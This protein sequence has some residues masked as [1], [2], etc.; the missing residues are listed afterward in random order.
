MEAVHGGPAPAP[1]QA[2][3]QGQLDT[4]GGGGRQRGRLPTQP[5]F[6]CGFSLSG[7]GGKRNS[8][9]TL[10]KGFFSGLCLAGPWSRGGGQLL[11]VAVRKLSWALHS[12]CRPL[13][14]RQGTRESGLGQQPG[15]TGGIISKFSEPSFF[16]MCGYAPPKCPQA[17]V[18]PTELPGAQLGSS[19]TSIRGGHLCGSVEPGWAGRLLHGQRTP[20]TQGLG[21]PPGS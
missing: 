3:P 18:D 13:S 7:L 11:G 21:P 15:K 12:H 5:V 9:V 10:T 17:S 8:Q 19:H 20:R 14:L 6:L 2:G 16:L 4:G 1:G